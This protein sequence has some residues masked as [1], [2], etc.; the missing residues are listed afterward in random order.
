MTRNLTQVLDR[1]ELPAP[2]AVAMVLATAVLSKSGY[3][4]WAI[5]GMIAF[6]ALFSLVRLIVARVNQTT[7]TE[8]APATK[9]AELSLVPAALESSFLPRD[10]R[11]S[12]PPQTALRKA[13]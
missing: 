6:H 10:P 4:F 3:P 12:A 11:P 8:S 1:L 9:R 5:G 13:A 7:I 2:V